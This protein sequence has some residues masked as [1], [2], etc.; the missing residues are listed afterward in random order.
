[1]AEPEGKVR[2]LVTG[3]AG[4]DPDA[5]ERG[6]ADDGGAAGRLKVI[7]TRRRLDD[8]TRLVSDWV[9]ETDETLHLTFLSARVFEAVGFHPSELEGR[10]LDELGVF[11]AADGST[12]EVRWRSPFRNVPFEMEARDGEK[13]QFLVSG[14]PVFC[15]RSGAFTGVRGTAEDVTQRRATEEAL[16][17]RE[18]VLE[19][20][21]FAAG[22]FVHST[23][24]RDEMAPV[25]ARL[26]EAAGA[27]WVSVF[28]TSSG[29]GGEAV[30]KRR[31]QWHAD[32]IEA[33]GHD[34][35]DIPLHAFGFSSWEKRLRAGES[36]GGPVG[37]LSRGQRMFL[38]GEDVL[39]I[40][41]VPIHAG[42]TWWGFIRFDRSS[43]AHRWPD[44]EISAVRVAA[45]IIGGTIHR[46]RSEQILAESEARFSTAFQ[47]SPDAIA[48][49]RLGDGVFLEVN[50]GFTRITGYSRDD[51]MRNSA[52]DIGIW[53]DSGRRRRLV[54]GLMRHGEV[55]NLEATFLMKDGGTRLGAMSAK[56][57]EINGQ[58]CI[59]SVTRD[60]TARQQDNELIQKLSQTVEQ[61]PVLV[62]ITSTDG[63]IEYVNTKF[64]DTT[65]YALD[66]MIGCN[67]RILNSGHTS[68][69]EF[70]SMW[71]TI[72][73]GREWRGELYN[74]KKNG[75]FFWA[76]TSISS[77]RAPDG[78]ITHFVAVSE[79]ITAR[80]LSEERILHQSQYDSLTELPN[81]TLFFDRLARTLQR[82]RRESGTLALMFIDLDRF[83]YV[84]E[85]LGHDAGDEMLR[86]AA[87]RL[88]ANAG[89]TNMI[90]RLGS[91][92]FAVVLGEL[93]DRDEAA[94][95]ARGLLDAFAQPFHLANKDI[96]VYGSIG[97]ALYPDDG[98]DQYS[99]LKNAATAM[100]RA[101]EMGGNTY[102]FF[103]PNMA[104]GDIEFLTLSSHLRH[105]L[106]REELELFYQPIVDIRS[107]QVVGSEALLRWRHPELGLVTPDKF[108]PL[109]EETGLVEPIGEWALRQ[110]CRQNREWCTVG[111]APLRVS[112]NIS[113][114][115]IKRGRLVEAV[116]AALT[117]S[118]LSPGSLALELTE[119]T[120][121]ADVRENNAVM[122][123]LGQLGISLSVD[124]FGT[125]YSSLAYLKRL[126]LSTL[127]IDR[128]FV[129]DVT[130][131]P[132]AAAIV[133]TIIVMA[134]TLKMTV[135]A[136]GVETEDQL[137]FL[138]AKG[139]EMMQ[140]YYFSV[141]LTASEF[142]DMLREGRCLSAGPDLFTT[143]PRHT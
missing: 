99:I 116:S 41:V 95:V 23:D 79:D 71:A 44:A 96:Y 74:R 34:R 20:V 10:R 3:V 127:K 4:P 130:T 46:H 60:I 29:A 141:P 100:H 107:G 35:K 9:W 114:H 48:I 12:A 140:G 37:T 32:G 36:V 92:E 142:T 122:Y 86:E 94:A 25:I 68:Q 24:W 39:S 47:T 112:V 102:Q 33:A 113:S 8:L 84:N 66:E 108:I 88:S 19:A 27:D 38:A 5:G 119:S 105:A 54:G 124:D 53:R 106:E 56:V 40:L 80:K 31:F 132:D 109:A 43:T 133:E 143:P 65:G 82:A 93:G 57:I 87:R 58:Q 63:S 111:S 117:Y 59:L 110:A 30:A 78:T 61:S 70:N 73:S 76:S 16:R 97:I 103:V 1:M 17:R 81:R 55:E 89:S 91:D 139:C 22:A 45:S 21:S 72:R 6:E 137:D 129:H 90:A 69:Q 136:E 123:E 125:G 15:P 77:I 52:L 135:I 75:E 98:E 18:A 7:D 62:M 126:P 118:G 49:N 120:F 104:A 83:K 138:R 2:E 101:K 121:L 115:Q 42:D 85:T 14:L 11:T 128:S 26:G 13:H 64:I 50:E 131:N 51:L 67:P 134:H 28:E